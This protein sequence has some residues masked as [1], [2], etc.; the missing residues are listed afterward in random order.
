MPQRTLRREVAGGY[1]D[2]VKVGRAW[3]FTWR[4]A[5]C[6]ALERWTW[7]EIHDALGDNA[8]RVLPPLLALR[9]LT[10]QLPEYL[11]QALEAVAAEN[12]TTLDNALHGELLDFAGTMINRM[13]PKV[14]GFRRAYLFPDGA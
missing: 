9:I 1:R 5:V 2:A 3:R 12:G 7:A 13:D 6:L 8:A 11:V 4:Q 14:P 10:V